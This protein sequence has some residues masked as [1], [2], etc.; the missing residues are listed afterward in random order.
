MVIVIFWIISIVPWKNET[1]NYAADEAYPIDTVAVAVDSAIADYDESYID[2]S[3]TNQEYVPSPYLGNQLI[4]GASPLD[5][6]FGKGL[7]NGRAT[8]TIKNGGSSDAIICLYSISDDRTIRNEYVQKDS[9]FTMSNISQGNYKI[10]VFYGNDWNPN[11]TNSCGSTGNFENN[12]NFSEFDSTDYFEDSD[13]GHTVATIT[14][15][16][17]EGGNASSSSIDQSTFF[18]K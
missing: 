7:Y 17:V 5:D 2:S 9:N 8:L 12:V 10:R 16:T 18:K 13:R 11:L 6:C 14:L 4:N 3:A 1:N 15:Y